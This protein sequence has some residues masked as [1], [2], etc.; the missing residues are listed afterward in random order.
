MAGTDWI[1]DNSR[2]EAQTYPIA[3]C[4]GDWEEEFVAESAGYRVS[5][6]AGVASP[7]PNVEK[8]SRSCPRSG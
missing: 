6:A 2:V 8:A 5:G 3:V 1:R 7:T 4:L